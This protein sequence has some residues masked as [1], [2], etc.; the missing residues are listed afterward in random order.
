MK[1]FVF[2]ILPFC[3]Y[4]TLFSQETTISSSALFRKI[5]SNIHIAY[6]K[7]LGSSQCNNLDQI[8]S[9]LDLKYKKEK[10]NLIIYWQ[11]Y[12]K[13]HKTMY[14]MGNSENKK[15]K[16][17]I[18][19]GIEKLKMIKN[20]N[21]ED[22][23]LLALLECVSL[24]LASMGGMFM[25]GDINNNI[26]KAIKL[27][28]SNIRAYYVAGSFDYYTPEAFGGGKLAEQYLLKAISLPEQKIANDYLPSWGKEESYALLIKLYKKQSKKNLAKKYY[29]DAKAKWG[30]SKTFK[31]F[32]S[33]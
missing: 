13:F 33:L 17:E 7:D 14:Y 26:K 10:Q 31:S 12:V 1:T 3:C 11:S 2:F 4:Q 27:D 25:L 23:A 30:N 8:D 18:D 28:T 21:S 9:I 19:I 32:D 20:K 5:Q 24:P 16:K 22:Y 29:E 6:E 15:A